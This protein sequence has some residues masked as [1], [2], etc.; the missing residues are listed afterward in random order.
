[1]LLALQMGR[2]L[3]IPVL[4]VLEK[5]LETPDQHGLTWEKPLSTASA[6]RAR[7]SPP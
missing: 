5:V 2:E 3:G 6:T 4:L 7:Y 1:M